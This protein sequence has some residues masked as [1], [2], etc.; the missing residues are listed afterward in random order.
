[1]KC[2]NTVICIK[3]VSAERPLCRCFDSQR[4]VSRC[5]SLVFEDDLTD[6][7]VSLSD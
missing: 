5:L 3:H 2:D 4:K 7:V 6:R 1:M